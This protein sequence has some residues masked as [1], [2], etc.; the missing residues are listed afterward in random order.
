MRLIGL[1][2]TKSWRFPLTRHKERKP[3]SLRLGRKERSQR[4]REIPSTPGSEDSTE[5]SIVASRESTPGNE[6]SSL[7][8]S[9]QKSH[10][11][12]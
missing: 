7:P 1:R 5:A 6:A 4:I 9:S 3:R 8:S 10:P 2:T 12:D 11:R